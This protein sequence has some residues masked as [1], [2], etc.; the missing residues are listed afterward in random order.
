MDIIKKKLELDKDKAFILAFLL[1]L[2]LLLTH[3][4]AYLIGFTK[5]K[6]K[7]KDFVVVRQGCKETYNEV[8]RKAE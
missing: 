1:C 6:Y 8:L 5:G 7:D 4:Q 3:I 2:F